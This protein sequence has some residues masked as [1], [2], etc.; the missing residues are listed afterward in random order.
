MKRLILTTLGVCSLG[1]WLW[2][3]LASDFEGTFQKVEVGEKSKGTATGEIDPIFIEN[4]SNW[5]DVDWHFEQLKGD[6]FEGQG[7]QR[8]T[9]KKGKGQLYLA[10]PFLRKGAIIRLRLALR[11]P[12]SGVLGLKVRQGQKPY[13][14]YW[15]TQLSVT[16]E[17]RVFEIAIPSIPKDEKG[18][19]RLFLL[20]QQGVIDIDSLSLRYLDREEVIKEG[21]KLDGNLL[22][23]SSFPLG[24]SRPWRLYQ[25]R[26]GST[27][28]KDP[29]VMGPTGVPALK[30]IPSRDLKPDDRFYGVGLV[31][32]PFQVAQFQKNTFSFYAKGSEEGQKVRLHLLDQDRYFKSHNFA[33]TTEWQRYEWS[34]ELPFVVDNYLTARIFSKEVFWLDGL[35]FERGEKASEFQRPS[36]SELHLEP[37]ADWGL[38][39]EREPWQTRVA[40]A[41][42]QPAGAYL[43]GKLI[44]SFG[45]EMELGKI[46]YQPGESGEMLMTL[47]DHPAG[48]FGTFLLQLQLDDANGKA[49]S[50]WSEA[51]LHRVRAPRM[52]GKD[53]PDSPFGV[54]I[55]PRGYAPA[56][57][58]KLGFNWVRFHGPATGIKW[59]EVEPQ[60]G[61]WDFSQADQEVKTFRDNHLMILGMVDTAPKFYTDSSPHYHWHEHYF[62]PKAEHHAKWVDYAKRI[63]GRYKDD[64]QVWEIW[65]EPF[66]KSFFRKKYLKGDDFEP[67][68]PADYLDLIR[69][70]APAVKEADPEATVIWS[71]TPHRD[72]N[73]EIVNLGV[74][75]YGDVA[76]FHYYSNTK[77]FPDFDN[78]LAK[79][80][81]NLPEENK[82]MPFWNTEGASGGA[83]D[84]NLYEHLPAKKSDTELTRYNAEFLVLYQL[85][86]LV[87]GVEKYFLYTLHGPQWGQGWTILLSDGSLPPSASAMSNLFWHVE[88][89]SYDQAKELGAGITAY[90]FKGE[91]ETVVV[92]VNQSKTGKSMVLD[93]LPASVKLRNLYGNEVPVDSALS[94]RIYYLTFPASEELLPKLKIAK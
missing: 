65:N 41:G 79:M 16:P 5:T 62:L 43:K 44:D 76:S 25:V 51:V 46:A 18:G 15:Q 94:Q 58:K 24:L 29:A 52:A 10:G 85:A 64:I 45:E 89:K 54:H 13:K 14:I 27:A 30:L 37:A 91:G 90:Q 80:R 92:L 68:T 77:P 56:V 4:S 17:W 71:S 7:A 6:V 19:Y 63:V 48:K 81:R 40:V 12:S 33:L 59:G 31:V 84:F 22:V 88:N 11:A 36:L 66:I 70:A 83:N 39:L 34:T 57:A 42:E 55:E 32:P 60:P 35:Q 8:I 20:P 38:S 28:E 93:Q 87:H 3:D 9:L 50:N 67:G 47:P 75:N 53:A 86:G 78:Y 26:E 82:D 21:N 23:T 73:D 74:P 2:A 1:Q 72:W 49:L 61:E 69:L